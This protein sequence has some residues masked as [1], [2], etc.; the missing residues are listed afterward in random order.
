MITRCKGEALLHALVGG[1]VGRRLLA[2][3]EE[4]GLMPRVVTPHLPHHTCEPCTSFLLTLSEGRP[5]L[6]AKLTTD[7]PLLARVQRAVP[8]HQPGRASERGD[9]HVYCWMWSRTGAKCGGTS[10]PA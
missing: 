5:M 3:N 9:K 7:C 8:N 1:T 2:R 4:A 6:D 10:T